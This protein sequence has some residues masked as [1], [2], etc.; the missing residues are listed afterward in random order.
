MSEIIQCMSCG[1]KGMVREENRTETIT[2]DGES[3]TLTG[4]SGW[5]CPSCH[6]GW[7]DDADQ[8]RYAKAGDELIHRARERQSKELRRI[9]KK[10]GLTQKEAAAIFGGG[11][12]AFSRYERG[13]I[14]PNASTRKLLHL[15]DKH[16]ELLK[17]VVN[18]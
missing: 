10:L 3:L 8:V 14:E 12:N 4:L 16:P 18:E 15:L 5:F 13:E 17:E 6:D 9:R 11:V 1:Y 2:H 7:F